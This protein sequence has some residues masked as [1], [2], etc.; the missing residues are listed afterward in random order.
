MLCEG[1][2]ARKK[3]VWYSGSPPSEDPA[4]KQMNSEPQNLERP[5]VTRP[6]AFTIPVDVKRAVSIKSFLNGRFMSKMNDTR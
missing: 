2:S 1:Q 4:D 5:K 6:P 3:V